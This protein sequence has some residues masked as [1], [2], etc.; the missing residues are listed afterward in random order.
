MTHNR[1]HY[2]VSKIKPGLR[3]CDNARPCTG[4]LKIE[5][6][7]SAKSFAIPN[8]FISHR[9]LGSA[10]LLARNICYVVHEQ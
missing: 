6:L 3:Q 1:A 2:S 4:C 9:Y 10:N 5:S 8:L 7:T